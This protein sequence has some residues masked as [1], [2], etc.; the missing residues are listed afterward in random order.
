M[1]VKTNNTRSRKPFRCKLVPV[2]LETNSLSLDVA[3]E[4]K[5]GTP[6]PGL[7]LKGQRA[8]E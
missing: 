3:H 8:F 4:I 1:A 5:A 6:A 7:K 2:C